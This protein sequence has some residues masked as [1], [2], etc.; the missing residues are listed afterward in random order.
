MSLNK[1]YLFTNELDLT[2]IKYD[3]LTFTADH[4]VFLMV[5][6]VPTRVLINTVNIM[7]MMM[8]MI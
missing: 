7:M 8:M 1:F 6:N 3:D 5:H 2:R 4:H